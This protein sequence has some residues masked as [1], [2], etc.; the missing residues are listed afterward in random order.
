MAFLRGF[1]A[2]LFQATFALAVSCAHAPPDSD[3]KAEYAEGESECYA[4]MDHT[5]LTVVFGPREAMAI[6]RVNSSGALQEQATLSTLQT[7]SKS[8]A[9]RF[10]RRNVPQTCTVRW[11]SESWG[12]TVVVT[13]GDGERL[14]AIRSEFDRYA[15]LWAQG[16]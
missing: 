15:Q 11:A 8:F 1:N 16:R 2:L 5:T 7:C 6:W 12:T 13:E 14:D 4:A 3:T 9:K 10:E